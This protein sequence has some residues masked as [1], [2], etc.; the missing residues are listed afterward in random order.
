MLVE[1]KPTKKQETLLKLKERII[2]MLIDVA[3]LP[4]RQSLSFQGDQNSE[5]LIV[6]KLPKHMFQKKIVLL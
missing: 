4:G 6:E 1:E 3:R 2:V 5:D